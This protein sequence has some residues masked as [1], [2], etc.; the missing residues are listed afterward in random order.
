[1]SLRASWRP[2]LGAVLGAAGMLAPAFAGPAAAT[3]GATIPGTGTF[4]VG[5]DIQPGVYRSTGNTY[6]YWHRA[7]DAS[8][9]LDSIIANDIGGGQRLVYLRAT[10]K[11]FKTS[12]CGTWSRVPDA[13]LRATSTATTIPG[14]GWYLVGAEFLP[15]TYRSTGNTDSCYWARSRSAD[16]E[17]GS[18]ITNDLSPGQLIVTIAATDI[19]F[20]TTTCNTWTRIA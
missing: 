6:C 13:T 7:K 10:D 15:G 9:S 8:G 20:Q 14:N 4:L 16:G 11:I 3:A 18:I 5:T 17:F 2:A 1:M 12:E 19:V